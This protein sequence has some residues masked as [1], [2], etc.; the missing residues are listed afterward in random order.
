MIFLNIHKNNIK[1]ESKYGKQK[2][3]IE[4]SQYI[5]TDKTPNKCV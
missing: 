5:G 4:C 1:L 2:I 3:C